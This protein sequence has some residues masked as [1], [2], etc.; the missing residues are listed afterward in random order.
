MGRPGPTWT[1]VGRYG[2]TWADM[3]LPP[4]GPMDVPDRQ[5]P[6]SADMGR[7]EPTWPTWADMGAS[8]GKICPAGTP[9][10]RCRPMCFP[11][12][13]RSSWH[14]SVPM[15]ADAPVFGGPCCWCTSASPSANVHSQE[16]SIQLPHIG[17]DVGRCACPWRPI[18]LAHIGTDIGR[19]G[20]PRIVG[21]ATTHRYRHRPM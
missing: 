2:P 3:A 10:Y 9:R 15:S 12:G 11:E 16:R 17:T 14:T 4:C 20:N 5:W 13:D 21:P 19:C 1:D 7:Y 8:A 6:V 18:Q